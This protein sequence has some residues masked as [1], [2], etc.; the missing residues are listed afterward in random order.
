MIVLKFFTPSVFLRIVSI[1]R[2]TASVRSSEAA[3]GS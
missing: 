2:A 3:G 1:F